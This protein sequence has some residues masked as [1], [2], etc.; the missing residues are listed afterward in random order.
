MKTEDCHGDEPEQYQE[1]QDFR[2]AQ[3]DLDGEEE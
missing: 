2:E 1:E 3:W